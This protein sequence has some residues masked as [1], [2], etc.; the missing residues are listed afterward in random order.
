MTD[1]TDLSLIEAANA[2]RAGE[3]SALSLT[4]ACLDRIASLDPC[5]HA[6]LAVTPELALTQA[7]SA[8]E[9]LTDWRRSPDADLSLLCGLPIAVKDVLCLRD[10]PTTAG[11][12][13]LEGFRPPYT[14]TSVQRLIDAGVVILGKTNTDE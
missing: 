11:S 8:D 2:L 1:L 10:V 6:F 3:I 14:A 12:R 4:Q 13:I 9:R 5:L 7:R